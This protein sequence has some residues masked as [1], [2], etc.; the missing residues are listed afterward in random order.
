MSPRKKKTEEKPAGD[1]PAASRSP[2]ELADRDED[3]SF[4]EWVESV[5]QEIWVA[6]AEYHSEKVIQEYRNPH[7]VGRLPRPDGTASY[8]GPCGDTMIFDMQL[9]RGA[10][11]KLQRPETLGKV[12]F[13]TDGCGSSV[14][15]G[16]MTTR[17]A[18]GRTIAGAR[19]IRPESILEALDGLPDEEKH[20]AELSHETLQ[21]AL[22][23]LEQGLE[24]ADAGT[25]RD[26]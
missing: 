9:A 8:R 10:D 12:T 1:A 18:E 19:E 3:L 11:H 6:E 16:S 23:D 26:E 17:L 25:A 24:Q 14:A 21:R 2:L 13:L 22:D 4:D 15:S 7:N 20:C 5:Q